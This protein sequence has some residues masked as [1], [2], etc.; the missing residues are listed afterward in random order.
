M[1]IGGR[2]AVNPGVAGDTAHLLYVVDK[3]A[4]RRHMIDTVN[5][6]DIHSH[7]ECLGG[8]NQ[9]L[10]SILEGLHY[11]GLPFLILLA[12]VGSHQMPAGRLHPCFETHVNAAGKRVVEQCLMS[13]QKIVNAGGNYALLCLIVGFPLLYRQLA[14]I[15]TDVAPFH[16]TDIQHAGCHLKRTD[17]FEHHVVASRRI[18][19]SR[20]GQC[21]QRES[22]A[23]SLFQRSQIAAQEPVVYTELLA[24]GSYR[25]RF[26]HHNQP[27]ATVAHEVPDV[28]RQQQ[29]GRE[30]KQ[31]D[32]SLAYPAVDLGF[33]FGRKVGRGIGHTR[34]AQVLQT[35]H[36]V[37][38]KRLERR[39]DQSEQSVFSAQIDGRKL[40]EQRFARTG[41]C[42]KQHVVGQP[43]ILESF[44]RFQY[45][46]LNQLPLRNEYLVFS[47]E[48]IIVYFKATK[49]LVAVYLT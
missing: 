16:R 2:N 25:M 38:D 40:E 26:V 8:H 17:G 9:P 19:D 30:V 11:L 43:V 44:L 12:I 37:Y 14:D 29:L 45:H 15:E 42:G 32:F 22:I 31:I 34:V 10:A 13:F 39:H 36:L 28:V 21:K 3:R 33:L 41:R 23:Q 47:L 7:A 18:P 24:P 1:E 49:I 5:I 35:L 48:Q 4:R 46:L 27:D 20:C 6:A